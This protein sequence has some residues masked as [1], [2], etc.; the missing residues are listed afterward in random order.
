MKEKFPISSSKDY[1]YQVSLIMNKS[2]GKNQR[3][4]ENKRENVKK[5]Y[6]KRRM[7]LEA[8]YK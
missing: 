3:V 5:K 1:K 6:S 7:S 4:K 2:R 8:F